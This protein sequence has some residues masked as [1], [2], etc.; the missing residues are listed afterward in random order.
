ME[1][2]YVIVLVTT[3]NRKEAEKIS[4]ALLNERLIACANIIGPISSL[5]WWREK[6]EGAE[7]YVLL[8]KTRF[9]MFEKLTEKVKVLHSYEVPE[10]IAIPIIQGFKPYLEWLNA[11]VR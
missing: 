6:I 2:D 8:M 9:D 4:K 10:I 7:E 5:F 3:A 11:S 1:K